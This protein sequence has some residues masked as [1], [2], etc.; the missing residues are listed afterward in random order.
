MTESEW[1]VCEDYK[2]M[3]QRVSGAT[4]RKVWLLAVAFARLAV[5]ATCKPE[6]RGILDAVERTADT[7]LGDMSAVRARITPVSGATEGEDV[8]VRDVV[9]ADP[10]HAASRAAF[11]AVRSGPEWG[12]ETSG[13][14]D[15]R[16]CGL[17]R[18]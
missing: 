10:W 12:S 7:L 15:R 14:G 18:D 8:L 6:N 3:L 2:P 5:G 17:V 11:M 13:A 4:T 16:V 9:R 1:L